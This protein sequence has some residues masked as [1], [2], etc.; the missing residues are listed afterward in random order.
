[1]EA[2][3]KRFKRLKLK[4]SMRVSDFIHPSPTKLWFKFVNE[5]SLFRQNIG[6]DTFAIELHKC[7][8]IELFEYGVFRSIGCR[9]I[10]NSKV[11]EFILENRHQTYYTW[12]DHK[13][14]F[15]GL[16]ILLI[17]VFLFSGKAF[18][19]G[20]SQ[21]DLDKCDEQEDMASCS[22]VRAACDKDS[23]VSCFVLGRFW[24]K[25]NNLENARPF[26]ERGCGLNHSQSCKAMSMMV[27]SDMRQLELRKD[28]DSKMKD[29]DEQQARD[30]AG[31]EANRA[32][33]QGDIDRTNRWRQI[34]NSVQEFKATPPTPKTAKCRSIVRPGNGLDGSLATQVTE[35]N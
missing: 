4:H 26:I 32:E 16:M 18:A 17:M 33:L 14:G 29:I 25:R 24:V 27:Q 23:G 13:E 31:F 10:D 21:K 1:M 7:G 20:I 30:R 22:K 28:Y 19:G 12:R 34:N 2:I 9:N 35:C 11:R 15:Q 8:A 3:D 5:D 6:I